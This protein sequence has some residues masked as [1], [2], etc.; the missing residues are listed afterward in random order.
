MNAWDFVDALLEESERKNEP[1][2]FPPSQ[3]TKLREMIAEIPIETNGRKRARLGKDG[4][5]YVARTIRIPEN[6]FA[7][8]DKLAGSRDVSFNIIMA[9]ACEV[10]LERVQ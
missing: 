9:E 3:V 5:K 8:L 6:L 2:S 1:C 4:I 7:Q 10:Y